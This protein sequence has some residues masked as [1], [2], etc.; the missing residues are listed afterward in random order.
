MNSK[1]FVVYFKWLLWGMFILFASCVPKVTEKKATCGSSQSFSSKTRDCI[2]EKAKARN[3]PEAKPSSYSLSEGE[4]KTLTLSYNDKDGDLARTCVV[5]D[6]SSDIELFSPKMSE[7]L[8]EAKKLRDAINLDIQAQEAEMPASAHI[9]LTKANLQNIDDAIDSI[10]TTLGLTPILSYFE[11]IRLN[12]NDAYD[13]LKLYNTTM[14]LI[15]F[16]A[17]VSDQL[18]IATPYLK[19]VADRC[20]CDAVGICTTKVGSIGSFAGTVGFSFTVN[21]GIDG[22]S[23]LKSSNIAVS[24]LNHKPFAPFKFVTVTE[25]A[26]SSPT[27]YTG[28]TLPA[29][30]DVDSDSVTSSLLTQ[31]SLGSASCSSG[32]CSY[33]P[34]DGDAFNVTVATK[35]KSTFFGVELEALVAGAYPNSFQINFKSIDTKYSRYLVSTPVVEVNLPSI[36]IYLPLNYEFTSSELASWLNG[37]SYLASFALATA[38]VPS[39]SQTAASLPTSYSMSATTTGAGGYDSFTYRYTDSKGLTS[40]TGTV[41]V[42]VTATNDAPVP[43]VIV[44]AP[45]QEIFRDSGAV[46]TAVYDSIELYTPGNVDFYTDADGDLATMCKVSFSDFNPQ[47]VTPSDTTSVPLRAVLNTGG[48]RCACDGA[49]HCSFDLKADFRQ[50]P[51]DV[52]VYYAFSDGTTWS[53]SA[54]SMIVK[55]KPSN[56]QPSFGAPTALA[57][58]DE[59]DPKTQIITVPIWANDAVLGDSEIGVGGQNLKYSMS[60]TATNPALFDMSSIVVKYETCNPSCTSVIVTNSTS[61]TNYVLLGA[62]N[63]VTGITKNL[64]VEFTP[65]SNQAGDITINLKLEDVPTATN[66]AL[67]ELALQSV[68][69]TSTTTVNEVN[70]LALITDSDI[71][72][73]TPVGNEVVVSTEE[74]A[75]NSPILSRGFILD[76]GGGVGEDTQLVSIAS[77]TSDNTALVSVSNITPIFDKNG[78]GVYEDLDATPTTDEVFKTPTYPLVI[79]AAATDIN[80]GSKKLLFKITPTPGSYGIANIKFTLTDDGPVNPA[81]PLTYVLSV[82]V[83]PISTIHGGWTHLSSTGIKLKKDGAPLTNNYDCTVAMLTGTG[84]PQGAQ[85]SSRAFSVY[86]DTSFKNCYY[87]TGTGFNNWATLN[88]YCPMSKKCYTGNAQ[89]CLYDSSQGTTIPTG[90]TNGDVY[91]T[92]NTSTQAVTCYKVDNSNAV[93]FTPTSTT[94][95]WKAFSISTSSMTI[96][97]SLSKYYIFR[98]KISEEYDLTK[99]LTSVASNILSYTDTTGFGGRAYHYMVVPEVTF[100]SKTVKV[101]PSEVFSEVRMTAPSA[102]YSFVHRWMVNQEVCNRMG[103]NTSMSAPNRVDPTNNYR[104]PFRG[105]GEVF[106]ASDSNYYYDIGSDYLVDQVENGCPFSEAP[107]CNGGSACVSTGTAKP[108]VSAA[109]ASVYYTRGNGKCWYKFGA[110]NTDWEEFNLA[111]VTPS[112]IGNR[113]ISSFNPPLTNMNK[114]AAQ[115]YCAARTAEKIHTDDVVAGGVDTGTFSLPSRKEQIAISAFPLKL[116]SFDQSFADYTDGEIQTIENGES[117]NTNAYCNSNYASGLEASFVDTAYPPSSLLYSMPGIQSSAIRSIVTGSVAWGSLKGT[118]QCVSR[119]GIQ[120]LFG[121]VAEWVKDDLEWDAVNEVVTFKAAETDSDFEDDLVASKIPY[122]FNYQIGPCNDADGSGVCD[123]ADNA[124]TDAWEITERQYGATKMSF[125]LGLPFSEAFET[126][127]P[128]SPVIPYLLDIGK[129]SGGISSGALHSDKFTINSNTVGTGDVNMITGGS[130]KSGNAAGRYS[131][132]LKPSTYSSSDVGF[133]CLAPINY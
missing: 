90:L 39:A 20:F 6:A 18:K 126:P 9:T 80:T 98:K 87:S 81:T 45:T 50:N 14:A 79:E 66:L 75:E 101:F 111:A 103:F 71:V 13:Q 85:N 63:G 10:G 46:P 1:S 129:T 30:L 51:G 21:D 17:A 33:L 44:G 130:F 3:L 43:K 24:K 99:P 102:N 31:G 11:V 118:T 125:P 116:Q 56:V 113:S 132:E 68:T 84:S 97:P 55:V 78:D 73:K 123:T 83:H 2:T 22:E 86:Y 70:D 91:A 15:Y 53:T 128:N 119:Y 38:L 35:A 121:N 82:I 112:S 88:T 61:L 65:K 49:G 109:V 76:E 74:T 127:Y 100:N 89:Q 122:Q 120:D 72:A 47:S 7:A 27:T 19:S 48:T 28:I 37:D 105:P 36:D 52:Q 8:V 131:F 64:K 12:A 114:A 104:C 40:N 4:V 32:S 133:R 16:N 95:S 106:D 62:G 26:T 92:I 25:S 107:T 59:D 69:L 77:L 29:G 23:I 94:L 115:T 67:G 57:S 41:V 54:Q 58:M 42:D 110:A 96:S 108:S 34:A 117:L 60:V 124:I 93:V 5:N